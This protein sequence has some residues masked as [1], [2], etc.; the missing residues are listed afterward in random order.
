M[1]DKARMVELLTRHEGIRRFPY[2]DSVGK[3]TIGIG[4]NLD[5]TGLFPEEMTFILENRIDKLV[6]ACTAVVPGYRALCQVRQMVVVDMA[7][8]LGLDGL[9]KFRKMM[10]ALVAKDYEEA[11]FQMLDSKWADQVG[12]RATR[13]SDMMRSGEW[14]GS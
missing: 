12:G 7:Y 4:F 2:K 11:A 8:N 9:L 6:Q 14:P 13:L 3:L 10:A 1:I 5:D